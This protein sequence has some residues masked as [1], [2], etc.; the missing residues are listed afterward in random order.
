MSL[1]SASTS[2]GAK[3]LLGMRRF[4]DIPIVWRVISAPALL[5]AIT[6]GLLWWIDNN[7]ERSLTAIA[8]GD[9]RSL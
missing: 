6:I 2:N 9:A 1:T 5:L 4:S 3:M 7:T 8:D